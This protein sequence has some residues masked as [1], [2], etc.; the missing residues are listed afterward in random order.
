[1]S[2]RPAPLQS[3]AASPAA[4]LVPVKAFHR[5]KRRLASAVAADERSR[6]AEAMATHVVRMAA[7]LPV[8]VVCDDPTVRAWAEAEGA[9]VVWCP[10]TGLNGAVARGV[11]T[12]A[13]R[14]YRQVVVVHGDLPLAAGL[15]DVVG[16]PGVTLVPDI[17]RDGT[18]VCAVPTGAG[19]R[20]AYGP[21]S[22]RR[23][24]EEAQ[25]LGLEL[26]E[27]DIPGLRADVDHPADLEN[28]AQLGPLAHIDQLGPSGK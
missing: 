13:V 25:R 8:T 21:G 7:P 6:L 16:W 28:L 15:H 24:C 23:H 9:A 20:F 10:G 19:F 4:V 27:L 12:L 17:R 18:N 5:A 3:D 1:M 2:P 11:A 22:F 14:G 26:R